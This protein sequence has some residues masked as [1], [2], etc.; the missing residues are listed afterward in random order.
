MIRK[1]L[2]NKELVRYIVVGVLTT[3]VSIA[4]YVL[5]MRCFFI[6]GDLVGV[7]IA[8]VFSWICAV[9]FAYYSNRKYVFRSD[10][11]DVLREMFLFFG[12]RITSLVLEAITL[13]LAVVFLE[14]ND[15]LSKFIAQVVVFVSNY[16]FSKL[17]VFK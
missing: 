5:C 1:L 16:I 17:V 8:N 11:K 15:T 6:A 3:I 7:Q 14:L 9:S 12:V 13:S 4:S 10:S 2:N